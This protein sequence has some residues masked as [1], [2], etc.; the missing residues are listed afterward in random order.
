MNF[1]KNERRELEKSRKKT[2]IFGAI[3]KKNFEN[4]LLSPSKKG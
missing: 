3:S 2:H 1:R 4:F